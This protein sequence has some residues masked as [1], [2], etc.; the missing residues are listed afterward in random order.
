MRPLILAT[1]CA[2]AP[3]APTGAADLSAEIGRT[4]L[5]ATEARLAALDAPADADRFALGGVRFLRAV[6]GALQLRWR[7]GLT[8][9]LRMLPFLRL[10]IAENPGPAAFDPASIAG[11]F[12][13]VAATMDAAR[14]PLDAIGEGSDFGLEIALSDLWF[15]INANARRDAG[16]DLMAV[17]G[18]M[19]LGWQWAGRDPATPA[20]VIRFDAAD[21]AWLSAYAHMLGGFSEVILAYDPTAAISRTL[22]ATAAIEALRTVPAGADSYAG[23]TDAA[24]IVAIVL[25]ALDQAPDSAR[26]ASARGHFLAMI[27]ENRR[28]WTRVAQETDN[29]REWLPNDAQQSALG[30][31]VPPGTGAVWQGVLAD[32]EA[33]LT[34]RALAPYWRLDAGAGVNVGAMFT[35]PAPIDLI[36]WIQGADALPY[37]ERGRVVSG[38]SWRAFGDLVS[39]EAMLFTLYLN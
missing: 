5:A 4:G 16:E 10:P 19:I 33:L 17:A 23:M 31:V 9:E 28:F 20:P 8:E 14:A 38:A 26:A 32:A 3:P 29:D 15:D 7:S 37:M 1:L 35:R 25:G 2:L 24:D 36:G 39:G 21:A 34:G 27:A 22:A 6:E 11:L 13:E 30:V 18:P 12:R